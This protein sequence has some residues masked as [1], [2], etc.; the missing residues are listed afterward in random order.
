[1][2][3]RNPEREARQAA[4]MREA[5]RKMD[6]EDARKAAGAKQA[7]IA[8]KPSVTV[9]IVDQGGQAANPIPKSTARP[10]WYPHPTMA[11][12]QRYWDGE[13]WTDHIAPGSPTKTTGSGSRTKWVILAVVVTLLLSGGVTGLLSNLGAYEADI[14]AIENEIER[15]IRQQSDLNADVECPRSIEWD[16]GRTFHCVAIVRG[17]FGIRR[18]V[19]VTMENDEG[20]L[21]WRVE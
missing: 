6:E 19:E 2:E 5:L 11:D 21:S 12:T 14:P 3:P 20:D 18:D 7:S 13:A 16:V 9:R 1:M 8:K 10:G 4:A 17:G 15:G